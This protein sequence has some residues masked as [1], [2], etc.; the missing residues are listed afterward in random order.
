MKKSAGRLWPLYLGGFLGPFGSPIVTTMLPELAQNFDVSIAVASTSVTSYLIP[1]ALLMVLS[2]TFAERWGRRRTVMIGYFA[3]TAATIACALAPN[4]E[5]FTLFRVLMGASNAFTT[6]VLVAAI[7]D[8]V[9]K[10]KL[11]RSLGLFGAMQATGQA[12]SPLAGGIAADIHWSLG[13][14]AIAAVSL[15]LALLP[16]DNAKEAFTGSQAERWKA[17]VNKQLAVASIAAALSFFTLMVVT[18]VGVLYLRDQFGTSATQTG[19]ILAI[20]GL[21]GLLTGRWSGSLMD[22]YGRL[23]IGSFAHLIF[24]VFACLI[25]VTALIGGIAGL[26]LA[27]FFLALAGAA[28]TATRGVVQQLAVTSAPTNRAGATS[29]MLATQ[30]LGASLAPILWMPIYRIDPIAAML[31]GG[32]AAFLGG[33]ILLVVWRHHEKEARA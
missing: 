2:G 18:V 14:Y 26:A 33:L 17:L 22:R 8:L 31:T 24:G 13:F 6:P 15:V 32:V 28:S 4:F 29:V 1:F 10:Q 19:V 3:Y 25:G 23:K 30:F 7:T 12:M 20:F 5:L 27:C 16:P 11:G 9:P 21:A